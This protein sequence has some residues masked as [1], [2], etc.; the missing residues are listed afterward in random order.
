MILSQGILMMEA[1]AL[2]TNGIMILR[3]HGILRAKALTKTGIRDSGRQNTL[4]KC[5]SAI[6]S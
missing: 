5:A 3:H 6:N 1:L 4:A 2:G